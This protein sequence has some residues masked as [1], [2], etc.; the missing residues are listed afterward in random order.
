[1]VEDQDT[2]SP[3]RGRRPRAERVVKSA[4]RA[5]EVIEFLAGIDHCPTLMEIA[6]ELD[7]PQ[8]SASMLMGSLTSLGYIAYDRHARTY[9]AAARIA[10]AGSI[11]AQRLFGGA[12]VLQIMQ[13][14]HDATGHLV[15]LAAPNRLNVRILRAIGE[16]ARQPIH[17]YAGALRPLA[18][19]ASGKLFL[20]TLPTH[21]VRSVIQR[22]SE[23]EAGPTL[24][25]M[26]EWFDELE[27]IRGRGFATSL[28]P[29]RHLGSIAMLM[30]T[31]EHA[32]LT[33]IVVAGERARIADH[34]TGHAQAIFAAI[35]RHAPN[36]HGSPRAQP[37]MR[38][39]AC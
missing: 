16:H 38:Q 13:E 30:P 35:R 14:L 27:V 4:A 7:I 2:C 17:Q 21:E 3:T 33:A 10:L 32:P 8:S 5:L 25:K 23:D 9:Q 39:M 20:S 22:L 6:R 12:Q 31:E 15:L 37:W 11:F 28:L 36:D 29:D 24:W 19:T 1:M 26:R 34:E 18:T